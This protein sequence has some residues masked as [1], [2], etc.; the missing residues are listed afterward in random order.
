[1]EITRRN[2]LH[3]ALTALGGLALGARPTAAQEKKAG[4]INQSWAWWCFARKNS[5]PAALIRE[6]AKMGYA[7]VDMP[8][9]NQWNLIRECGMKISAI[10]G[11]G[12][13][14]DGLNRREN[15]DR[16]EQELRKN[17]DAA[18]EVGIPNLIC[19]SGNRGGLSDE[20]GLKN[21]VEGF[22]R[23]AKHAEEK[24]VAL[25]ME[26]LNSKVN[27]KDYQCDHTAWGVEV[28][29]QVGSPAVK[30]LYDIYH[31]QIMEGDIIRT[32]RD[33]IAYIS[34][35]HTGGN[36]GRNDL[37][38]TQELYYPAIMRAIK[39]TGFQGYVAHEFVPKG[40]PIEALKKAYELCNV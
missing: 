26:L 24:K 32:I 13:L 7:A 12:K 40:D 39:E 22:K 37:D 31:M 9:P 20:E 10:G 11:H 38:E 16:I 1:M 2:V 35:F 29:K 17:I 3:M 5:D 4:R 25:A 14:T 19:F 18:A 8:P 21:T 33:N 34:H 6:S 27:H 30:L 36:P 15:H 28:C 23:V